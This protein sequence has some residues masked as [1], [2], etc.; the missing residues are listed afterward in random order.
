M[1]FII[2]CLVI[3]SFAAV[4]HSIEPITVGIA[5]FA[6]RKK[7]KLIS[8]N[9]WNECRQCKICIK[10]FW[11]V[12][13]K[14]IRKQKCFIRISQNNQIVCSL[15]QRSLHWF[16]LSRT[17]LRKVQTICLRVDGL[18]VSMIS[19]FMLQNNENTVFMRKVFR[20]F[21]R[22]HTRRIK[23]CLFVALCFNIGKCPME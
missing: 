17:L 12:C 11:N 5:T 23:I 22:N 20:I 21:R 9:E 19:H 10:G 16:S 2:F 8:I 14:C 3:N 18:C 1:R 6:G 4:V 15:Y 7:W 13:M